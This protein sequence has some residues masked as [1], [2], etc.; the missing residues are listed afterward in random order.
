MLSTSLRSIQ[1]VP[2]KPFIFFLLAATCGLLSTV[3]CRKRA[4]RVEAA[5]APPPAAVSVTD[6]KDAPPPSVYD[7]GSAQAREAA[8]KDRRFMKLALA[9]RD[10]TSAQRK[11]AK[12]E[13]QRLPPAERAEFE[14]LC[15]NMNIKLE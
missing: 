14:T 3:A 10:G 4:A 7:A 12:E 1:P 6:R 8:G 15:R 9:F 2:P 13:L 5:P 11:V